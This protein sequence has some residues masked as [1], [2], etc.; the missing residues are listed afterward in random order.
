VT[1]GM[2]K[3]HL[4]WLHRYLGGKY[5]DEINRTLLDRITDA[6]L[7]EGKRHGTVNR[8]LRSFGPS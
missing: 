4:R 8:T 6:R 1:I 7:A 5:L 2:D 3:A